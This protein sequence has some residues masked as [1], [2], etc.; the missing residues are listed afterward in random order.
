MIEDAASTFTAA[1]ALDSIPLVAQVLARSDSFRRRSP[2]TA[3]RTSSVAS[4]VEGEETGDRWRPEQ[5]HEVQG[6][7][8]RSTVLYLTASATVAQQMASFYTWKV[9]GSY[10]S[11][12]VAAQIRKEEATARQA[13]KQAELRL[14][15]AQTPVYK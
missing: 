13:A 12:F 6:D 11:A 14:R 4:L 3:S 5:V 2:S 8:H 7:A 15:L 1:A 9:D 10:A